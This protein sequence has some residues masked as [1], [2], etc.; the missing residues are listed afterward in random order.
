MNKGQLRWDQIT[1]DNNRFSLDNKFQPIFI[2]DGNVP[3]RIGLTTRMP[4]E[5]FK[6]DFDFI[7]ENDIPIKFIVAEGNTTAI[8]LLTLY[9]GVLPQ[10]EIKCAN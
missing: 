6:L 5:T 3:V 4:G 1:K 10:K 9:W 7:I 8:R 2:N